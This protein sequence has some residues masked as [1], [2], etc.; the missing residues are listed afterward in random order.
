MKLKGRRSSS[1]GLYLALAAFCDAAMAGRPLLVDDANVNDPGQGQLEAWVARGD[2]STVYNIAPAYAPAAG[3]EL[4]AL[5]AR[6]AR[7]AVTFSGI[8]AKWRITPS[9]EKGCNT[10]AVLGATHAPAAPNTALLNGL[11]TCNHPE[12]GSLHLNVGVSQARHGPG[13]LGWGIAFE[14]EIAGIT[15][16]VEWLGV[17]RSKPTVQVGLRGDLFKN[18]QLDGSVGRTGDATLYTVGTTLRF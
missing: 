3:L 5:L 10:G 15:P 4:G 12:L 11:L 1:A 18:V 17:Q 6:D 13:L 16:H 9:L 7:A 2:G 8:Q 14:R